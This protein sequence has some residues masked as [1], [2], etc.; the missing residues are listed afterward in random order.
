[1]LNPAWGRSVIATLSPPLIFGAFFTSTFSGCSGDGSSV[2]FQVRDS[3]GVQIVTI[4]EPRWPSS[5]GWRLAEEASLDIG[6]LDG[7]SAYQFHE[8]AGALRQDDGRI[9]VANAGS[10]EL[11]Q[12]GS[13]GAF[14]RSAGRQGGGPGEFE[15]IIW[16]LPWRGDSLAVFDWGHR[17]VSVFDRELEFG[18]AFVLHFLESGGFPRLIDLLPDGSLLVTVMRFDQETRTATGTQRAAVQILRADAEGTVVDSLGRFPGAERFEV[19]MGNFTIFANAAFG[20]ASRGAAHD[21]GFYFGTSDSYEIR[22]Y[23]VDGT[24]QRLIRLARPNRPVGAEDIARYKEQER[25]GVSSEEG[26]QAVERMLGA[27]P[28]PETFP[29]YGRFIVDAENN[30]WVED[31]PVPGSAASRWNVFDGGGTLLGTVQTP[32]NFTPYQI[33]A[34]FA[35][36]SW[37]DELDVEHVRLYP[38]LE[39]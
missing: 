18:R 22:D 12:F 17:R 26:R 37:R 21:D 38:L 2:G 13:D 30:L 29:A 31:Y 33:G 10:N 36:G 9:V 24:L 23:S 27:M 39:A 3:A 6:V 16:L 20:R 19:P 15:Q 7:D 1:M 14:L 25:A 34:D 5:T 4:T 32:A 28:F 11:R 8:I 35:L